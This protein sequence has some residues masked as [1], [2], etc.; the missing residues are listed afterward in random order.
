MFTLHIDAALWRSHL[1]SVVDRLPDIVPVAKGNG[2]GFGLT[3]LAS[4]SEALRRPVIAVGVIDELPLVHDA[5]RGDVLVLT[6]WH[7]AI[8]PEPDADA[9]LIVTVSSLEAVRAL[10]GRPHRA[11]VELL[12]SMRRFGLDE[13]AIANAVTD[14]KQLAL[15]GFALHLPIDNGELGRVDEISSW[16]STLR[17][18]QLPT[19]TLWV[20]HV[21]DAELATLR[22][23]HPETTFRPRIGTSL[24]LGERSAY[25]AKGTVLATH[26][27]RRGQRFGYR[28]RK[29]PGD[30]HLVVVG[31]GTSHGVALSAPRAVRG[32]TARLKLAGE[33]T[34]EAG[35]RAL[36]PFHIGGK[37]RW[38]AEPPHMQ[39]S[40]VWLPSGVTPPVVGAEVSV[41]VR[42]TTVTFDQVVLH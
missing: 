21:T 12:T 7:P 17:R 20:S 35:G 13:D 39:L 41:D 11:V 22:R 10:A 29:A 33:G 28:Q 9:R 8:D 26:R 32:A 23:R 24:W 6:P 19:E 3:T 31:G 37:R 1:Q 2:Y 30:G 27:L 38:F 18:H 34:L 42:M 4:E 16:V 14:L 25:Q 40:M 5:F 36:S 15:E